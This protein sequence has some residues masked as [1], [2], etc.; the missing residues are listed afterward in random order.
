[1]LNI[2]PATML[3]GTDGGVADAEALVV[4]ADV[5]DEAERVLDVEVPAPGVVEV[6]MTL[7]VELV[8]GVTVL[9]VEV[10]APGVVEVPMALELAPVVKVFDVREFE[11]VDEIV[12]FKNNGVEV[13]DPNVVEVP[14]PGVVEVPIAPTPAPPFPIVP[15]VVEVPPP[16]VVDVPI[17]PTPAPPFP[18]AEVKVTGVVTV[19]VVVMMVFII[20][21]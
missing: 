12:L 8:V 13:E 11:V 18:I 21:I 20:I 1:M 10:P 6:P 19:A 2:T 17:A 4:V 7:E 14:P 9:E 15:M 5:V 3:Y 16:G